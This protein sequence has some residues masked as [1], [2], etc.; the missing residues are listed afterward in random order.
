MLCWGREDQPRI[1]QQTKRNVTGDGV[2]VQMRC[3]ARRRWQSRNLTAMSE[4]VLMG[5]RR[6]GQKGIGARGWFTGIVY[7]KNFSGKDERC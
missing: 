6:V 4:T 3:N 2:V 1:V 7:L 5:V